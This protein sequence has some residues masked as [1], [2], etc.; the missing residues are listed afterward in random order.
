MSGQQ[1]A[2]PC[3]HDGCSG[4]RLPTTSWCLAHAEGQ[5]P[6]AFH[7]ELERIGVEG[8]VDCSRLTISDQLLR[9]LLAAAPQKD[10]RPVF[11]TAQFGGAS[12]QGE[13]DF[14]GVSFQSEAQ[15]GGARFHGDAVFGGARFQGG[16]VFGGATFKR[17]AR[18]SQVSFRGRVG[19]DW[20]RFEGRAR[21]VEANFHGDA[22]FSE[23]QF[24]GEAWFYRA[25]FEGGARFS[26]THFQGEARFTRARFQSGAWFDRATFQGEAGFAKTIFSVDAKFSGARFEH[27]AT[28][29][30]ASVQGEARF[31]GASFERATQVGPL[32][33]R[34]VVFDGAVFSAGVQLEVTAAA[35]CARWAQFPAGVH[36][37]LRFA[38]VVLDDA[39]LATTAILTGVPSWFPGLELEEQQVAPRW[40]QLPPGPGMRQWQPRLLSICRADVAGL[41]LA[42]VDL[43]A[44]RFVGAHNLDKLRIEGTP[45]LALPPPGWHFRR[46]GGEGL[47]IWHWAT[48]M[49]LAE[50]QQWRATRPLRPTPDGRRHPQLRGWYPPTCRPGPGLPERS[51][52]SPAQLA[53]L[54][55]ELRKG[56]EDTKDEPGA[57][58][59]YYGEMEM[60]RHNPQTSLGE[61]FVLWLYWLTSG[62][63][64]R[65]L[66]ALICL[67]IVVVVLAGLLH[68]VGFRP[69]HPVT[70]RSFWSSLLYAAESTLS[71]GGTDIRLT[72][73]GRALRIVLRLTGPVLLGGRCSLTSCRRSAR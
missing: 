4:V 64:L 3:K 15:F 35:V 17:R 8:T 5:A 16:A 36:L 26:G 42:D 23:T 51:I 12:F 20:A 72:G 67:A 2:A 41:R 46:V 71:L 37:R 21:F 34:Q 73:W 49:T 50:E 69:L 47:P 39:N 18:F 55:R 27:E 43:R 61:R 44:C 60:R 6:D 13:A 19:F 53:A 7:A 45:Q 24:Q 52:R 57:A 32:L 48:R 40:P 62:Y 59:F 1:P 30:G 58:D 68:V 28:F 65:G 38:S 56:L 25:R 33:A 9:R 31:S 70:P 22:G 14:G 63:S 11:M 29:G 54:Y 66:R 10:N